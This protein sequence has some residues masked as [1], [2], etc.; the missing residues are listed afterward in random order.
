MDG[1]V[2]DIQRFSIHDG[3]GIRTIV[4][5]KGCPL[6]CRWC[7]NPESMRPE[8]ELLFNP[9]LCIGCGQCRRVCPAGALGDAGVDRGRC[10]GCGACVEECYA[11]ALFMKGRIMTPG[12]VA[13]AALRDAP[14]YA[15]TGG[16]VTFSGGEP[17]LQI[18]FL[19]E[20]L[21]L[22]RDKGLNTAIETCG[23]V[24]W[25]SIERIAPLVDVFLFDIKSTDD[26]AHLAYTGAG[27]GRIMEN[28]E[29]LVKIANRVIVRIPVVPEF[30]FSAEALTDIVR[31]AERIGVGEVHF[32]PYHRMAASKYAFLGR[33]CWRPGVDR[34]ENDAVEACI[35]NI[36]TAVRLRMNG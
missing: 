13:A 7:C 26:G 5:L 2:F 33:E 6:H 25:E 15:R 16:G 14:F 10:T 4:F 28:C 3:P 29:R 24:P 19:E 12:E 8:P 22:C 30:N 20:T 1:C 35:R 9:G 34:L 32:L 27:C 11:D 31:F 23:H 17:L 18:D 21:R 36:E